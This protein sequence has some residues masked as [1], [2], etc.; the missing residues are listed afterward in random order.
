MPEQARTILTF[1]GELRNRPAERFAAEAARRNVTPAE[2]AAEI[3]LAA[4]NDNLY[5]AVLDDG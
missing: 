3:L 1:E 4:I 2:L 5:A